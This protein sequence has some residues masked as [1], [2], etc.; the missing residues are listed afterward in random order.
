[1][2]NYFKFW[3]VEMKGL[4]ALVYSLLVIMCT[5]RLTKKKLIFTHRM[6]F[7]VC[8]VYGFQYKEIL[9]PYTILTD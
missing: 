4:R 8:I 7:L 9:L 3:S 2:E 6:H 5:N 1:V